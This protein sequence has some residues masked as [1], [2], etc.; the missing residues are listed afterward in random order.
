MKKSSKYFKACIVMFLIFLYAPA[1]LLPIFSF[2]D[3]KVIAFPLSGFSTVWF[4]QL[5]YEDTLHDAL[6]NSLF[7][8]VSSS[9]LATVFGTLVARASSRYQFFGQRA[10]VTFILVPLILPE[11]ILGVCLLTVL[12]QLGLNLNLWTVVLGHTLL[13]TPFS[14]LIMVS[15]FNNLDISLEEASLDLGMSAVQTFRLIILPMVSPGLISSLLIGFVISLDE[16]II[17][18]FLTGV[19]PTLPVYIWAQFRFPAKLPSTMAL[20]TILLIVSLIL[21]SLFEYFRRRIELY[22]HYSM[23]LD[24]K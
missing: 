5:L 22:N 24:K 6:R 11:I 20:G 7:I 2:N 13:I 16:F 21:V 9:I 14:T 4:E 1:F 23:E 19:E 10:S 15:A 17:A 3:S 8:A 12:I 18:F